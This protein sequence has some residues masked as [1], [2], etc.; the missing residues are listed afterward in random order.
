MPMGVWGP[1]RATAN[2]LPVDFVACTL[3]PRPTIEA[4]LAISGLE[5]LADHVDHADMV[6]IPTWPILTHPVPERLPAMLLSAHQNGARIVGLCLGAFVVAATGLLDGQSATT[7]WRHRDRFEEQFPE[8]NFEPNTLYVDLGDVVTSAGSAAAVDCCL[9]LLRRDHGADVAATVARSMV[10]APH[11]SGTQ[12]Q[13][14]S[15]PVIPPGDDPISHG[16]SV[17]AENI[18]AISGVTDLAIASRTSRRSLERHLGQRL[19]ITPKA[20]IDEQRV[21]AASRLLETS[22][23]S[24]EEIAAAAGYGSTPTLR[25]AF[26]QHRQT[27]PSAYRSAFR[28]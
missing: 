28:R 22:D 6:I 11:R 4:G 25:R 12:S 14:A 9:Y 24:I 26:R 27:T 2:D 19:G 8:V 17:A 20:W 16:L 3:G 23:R 10:T 7:H 15:A 5:Q 1:H 13:F 18:G 21:I